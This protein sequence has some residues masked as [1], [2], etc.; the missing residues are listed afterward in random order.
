M[1]NSVTDAAA[2]YA[3]CKLS[4]DDGDKQSHRQTDRQTDMV[5]VIAYS[6][7]RG[8]GHSINYILKE[9]NIVVTCT[10]TWLLPLLIKYCRPNMLPVD[11]YDLTFDAIRFEARA[12]L[13][14]AEKRIACSCIR[15]E[16]R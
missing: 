8:A 1:T 13:R 10:S 11:F 7:F 4:V 9:N 6:P 5:I 15:V 16:L 2:P 3:E 12:S 14:P